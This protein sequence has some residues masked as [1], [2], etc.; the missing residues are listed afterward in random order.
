MFSSA[1]QKGTCDIKPQ[2]SFLLLLHS[3]TTNI[4]CPSDCFIHYSLSRPSR[5]C[6]KSIRDNDC[7][8]S[9]HTIP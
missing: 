1:S 9:A 8:S 4:S 3:L 7:A 6:A 2:K 5:K